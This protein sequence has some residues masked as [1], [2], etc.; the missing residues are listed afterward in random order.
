MNAPC[1][2]QRAC[3]SDACRV[4][5]L[6]RTS[7][8]ARASRP[9]AVPLASLKNG[10]AVPTSVEASHAAPLACLVAENDG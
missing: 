2:G 6:L 3:E 8:K 7:A 10:E 1:V 4:G 5:L 9:G